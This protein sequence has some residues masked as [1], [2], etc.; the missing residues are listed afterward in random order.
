MKQLKFILTVFVFSLLIVNC[1]SYPIKNT[2]N[3]NEEPVVI[4]NEA[5]EYEIIIIDQ[6]FTTFL[7]TEA[8]SKEYYSETYLKSKNRIYVQ[9]W[10]SRVQ[11][12]QRFN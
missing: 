11:N 7:N 4:S 8:R 6:G 2:T 9:I 10:N 3:I 1:G 12:P 5:L